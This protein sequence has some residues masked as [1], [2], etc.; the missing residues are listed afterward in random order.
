MSSRAFTKIEYEEVVLSV[1]KGLDELGFEY[2]RGGNKSIAEFEVTEPSRFRVTVEVSR[3]EKA[4]FTLIRSVE[5]ETTVQFHR[6]LESDQAD[7]P[8]ARD[9]SAF[10]KKLLEKLPRRPWDGLGLVRSKS[11]KVKWMELDSI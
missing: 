9:A 10:L 5:E 11:E 6:D 1:A 2:R 3:R 7:E 4:G 8:L